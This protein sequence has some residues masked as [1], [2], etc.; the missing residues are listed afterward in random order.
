[1]ASHDLQVQARDE[2]GKQAAKRLRREGRIPAVVYGRKEDPISVS[3]NAKELRDFLAHHGSHGLFS[4]KTEGAADTPALIKSLQRHPVKQTVQAI[5]FLRVSLTE[6]T[7]AIVP[8]ILTGE[9]DA[10]RVEGGVLVHSLHEIE[11]EAY[12]QDLPESIHVDVTGLEYDGAP[13]H[14][15][16]IEMPAN[17]VAITDGEEAIAVVNPPRVEEVDEA[18]APT[19]DESAVPAEHGDDSTSETAGNA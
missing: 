18:A 17:I 2:R 11:I 1:M 19:E 13:I 3:V 9:P 7:R 6:K 5:D 14:V 16:E 12:P 8:I 15:K 4:L 10:V